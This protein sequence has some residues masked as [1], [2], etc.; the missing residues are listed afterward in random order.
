M[1]AG[2]VDGWE[3]ALLCTKL[4]RLPKPIENG[5]ETISVYGR[6]A[7]LSIVIPCARDIR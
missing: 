6:T 5:I 1:A 3:G 4:H 7:G 2:L